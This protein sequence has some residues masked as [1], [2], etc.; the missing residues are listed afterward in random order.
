MAEVSCFAGYAEDLAH[1]GEIHI[2]VDFGTGPD[3]SYF[4][5][6]MTFIACLVLRGEMR[7]NSGL[8]L[9]P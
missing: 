8:R 3:A 9:L 7:P 1:M 5:P 4:D 6:S 2:F